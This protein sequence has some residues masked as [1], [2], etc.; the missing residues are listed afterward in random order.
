MQSYE[1]KQESSIPITSRVSILELAELDMYWSS[2]GYRPKSMSQLV[3]WSISL[4][5]DAL[6]NSGKMPAEAKSLTEANN[7][8]EER[9]LYQ[10]S[11][12]KRSMRKMSTA[13]CFEN[14]RNE[15]INPKDFVPQ[16]HN[17]LHNERSIRP[18]EMDIEKDFNHEKIKPFMS[19]EEVQRMISEI[20]DKGTRSVKTMSMEEVREETLRTAEKAGVFESSLKKSMNDCQVNQEQEAQG[21]SGIPRSIDNKEAQGNTGMPSSDVKDIKQEVQSTSGI[22]INQGKTTSTVK[23]GMTDEELR[24][25]MERDDEKLREEERA[26]EELLKTLKQ[27]S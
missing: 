23:E 11:L 10:K 6:K 16:Q 4:L 19:K 8:L 21:G 18:L 20:K 15:G 9:N 14:L 3:S 22:K 26:N 5:C 17:M 2:G 25:K 24:E 7:Y 27:Q 12:K 1:E 13:L